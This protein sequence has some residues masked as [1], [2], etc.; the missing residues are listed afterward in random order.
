MKIVRAVAVV[1]AVSVLC[2]TGIY[3]FR[4]ELVSLWMRHQLAAKLS[5]A[6]GAKV[7][8][9]EVSWKPGQLRAG[10]FRLEGGGHLRVS[11]FEARGVRAAVDWD[12]LLDPGKGPLHVE[13]DSL[14]LVWESSKNAASSSDA[15]S[16][17]QSSMPA[18]DI[19]VG[20]L[21]FR[22]ADHS[23][24]EVRDLA[25]HANFADGAWSIS[26][27]NGTAILPGTPPLKIDRI[28]AELRD[29]HL[30]IGSFALRDEKG[31][32]L[33]GS[34]RH[35]DDGWTGEFSWQD[36]TLETVLSPGV[37]TY[38][39]GHCSGDAQL[40]QGTLSGG[41][42]I[43]GGVSKSVP[44]LVKMASLF[45]RED[46]SEI[47]WETFKFDFV[48]PPDGR[49]EFSNLRAVSSKGLAVSGAGHYAPESVG[50][51]LQ[52]GVQ[53]EGRPWLVAFVPILFRG[54]NDGY[55]WTS[56]RVGGT[57]ESPTEDLT[58]RVVAALATAPATEAIDTAAEVPGAAVEA[59]GSLLRSLL[60]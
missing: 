15:A 6:L 48:R 18:M 10:I 46:W 35:A 19:D 3:F 60:R 11:Q 24:W 53:R 37:Q 38:F 56:V 16:R 5:E 28:S 54:E 14:D 22:H 50:A 39:V 47:P 26:G 59:A 17:S 9:Q 51:E 23:G 29:G 21:S 4:A 36:I 12:H 58:A 13:A 33:G 7:T 32:M 55:L 27:Q 41:M 1:L 20:H 52:F 31:G 40:K 25:T 57:P 34:A 45:A 8:L 2:A 44:Q 49:V 43:T 42:K 30:A